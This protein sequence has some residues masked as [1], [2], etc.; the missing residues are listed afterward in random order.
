MDIP[1]DVTNKL[2]DFF[3]S[4]PLKS[5]QRG[6]ILILAGYN[7]KN[8]YYLEKGQVRQYDISYDG[9]EVVVNVFKPISFFPMSWP[10]AKIPN[11]YFFE[12]ASNVEVREAPVASVLEFIKNNPD[13]MLDLLTR[14]YIGV[15]G[16]QRRM[17]HLMGGNAK[18]RLIF[19]LV[20]ECKRFG[21]RNSDGSCLIK[22]NEKEIG[23]RAGLAR[24]TVSREVHKLEVLN[25]ISVSHEGI[26]I[27]SIDRLEE[28]LDVN[29]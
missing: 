8:I 7:P 14:L 10:V 3:G 24:E 11:R 21:K 2:V 18:T 25:I 12:A 27:R 29:L 5:Y 4:Y 17:A 20:T 26:L 6:E 15:D 23:S 1:K 19:E 28:I 22:I 16:I 9:N 13:V